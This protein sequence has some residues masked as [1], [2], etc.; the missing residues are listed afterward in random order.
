MFN[1]FTCRGNFVYHTRCNHAC[2]R[3]FNLLLRISSILWK[4]R[5]LLSFNVFIPLSPLFISDLI[6]NRRHRRRILYKYDA[7]FRSPSKPRRFF[8]SKSN[9]NYRNCPNVWSVCRRSAKSSWFFFASSDVRPGRRPI[10]DR[11]FF[12]YDTREVLVDSR[13]RNARRPW[14]F[15]ANKLNSLSRIS[16][17]HVVLLADVSGPVSHVHNIRP[18]PLFLDLSRIPGN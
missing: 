11:T 2:L 4:R 13:T 15:V 10:L 7:L 8:C 9:S 6:E 3:F 1:D 18:S 16:E 12:P 17:D 14:T 5:T